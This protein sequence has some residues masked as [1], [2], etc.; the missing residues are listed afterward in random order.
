MAMDPV[1]LALEEIGAVKVTLAELRDSAQPSQQRAELASILDIWLADLQATLPEVMPTSVLGAAALIRTAA[2]D[3][4][5]TVRHLAPQ[6][7]DL[8]LVCH[9]SPC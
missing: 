1:L 6:R 4:P 9:R 5:Q 8:V 2:A 3:L 7:I